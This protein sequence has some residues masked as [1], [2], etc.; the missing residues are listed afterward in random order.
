[1]KPRSLI[2][3]GG[4]TSHQTYKY[5]VV[6]THLMSCNQLWIMAGY[7]ARLVLVTGTLNAINAETKMRDGEFDDVENYILQGKYI[8]VPRMKKQICEINVCM[9]TTS[10]LRLESSEHNC[11]RCGSTSSVRTCT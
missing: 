5:S 11:D 4:I 6:Q 7:P 9:Q 2:P 3:N 8:H 10:R 1:M